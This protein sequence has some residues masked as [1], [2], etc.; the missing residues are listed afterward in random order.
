[1]ESQAAVEGLTIRERQCL[2]L[3]AKGLRRGQIAE[4][5]RIKPVTAD[6]PLQNARKKLGAKTLGEA[7]ARAIMNSVTFANGLR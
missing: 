7:V 4:Q 5:L 6:L 1:V 2:T 3:L